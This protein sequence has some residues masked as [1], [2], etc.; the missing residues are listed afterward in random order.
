MHHDSRVS[1]TSPHAS[2]ARV[3]AAPPPRCDSA[4]DSSSNL[5]IPRPPPAAA[6]ALLG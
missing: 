5:A 3:A 4:L 1:Y 2:A 6:L